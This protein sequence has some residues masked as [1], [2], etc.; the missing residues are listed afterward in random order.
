M[1]TILYKDSDGN[2]LIKEQIKGKRTAM[3]AI[4]AQGRKVNQAGFVEMMGKWQK[5]D[6]GRATKVIPVSVKGRMIEKSV[7]RDNSMQMLTNMGSLID[8]NANRSEGFYRA[9]D[10]FKYYNKMKAKGHNVEVFEVN[11]ENKKNPRYY[12]GY[13]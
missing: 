8:S 4:N 2:A 7:T 13:K 9:K 6:A 11:T 5:T 3:Y 10:A 12:V 1:K